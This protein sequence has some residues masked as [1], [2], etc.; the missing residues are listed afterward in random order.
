[1]VF[2]QVPEYNRVFQFSLERRK[3][4]VYRWQF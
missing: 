2:E 4:N 1:M 3:I